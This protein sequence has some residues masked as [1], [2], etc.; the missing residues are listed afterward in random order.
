MSLS[1]WSNYAI[2]IC[3]H[4]FMQILSRFKKYLYRKLL[5]L[6]SKAWPSPPGGH[7]KNANLISN[8]L[9]IPLESLHSRWGNSFPRDYATWRMEIGLIKR[10]WSINMDARIFSSGELWAC[11]GNSCELTVIGH[12]SIFMGMKD[13]K[14]SKHRA[15]PRQPKSTRHLLLVKNKH[16]ILL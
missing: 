5:H 12:R 10:S 6:L 16:Y 13:Q 15:L 11:A 4:P 7:V 9:I 8:S 2:F 3:S 14:A 1:N